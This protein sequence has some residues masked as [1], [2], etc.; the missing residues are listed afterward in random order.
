[1]KLVIPNSL[2]NDNILWTFSD[3]LVNYNNDIKSVIELHFLEK[4]SPKEIK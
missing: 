1:M 4:I 3:N 2:L